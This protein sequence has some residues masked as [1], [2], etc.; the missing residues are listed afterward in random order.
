MKKLSLF[1]A[2]LALGLGMVGAGIAAY[3]SIEPEPVLAWSGTQ[4]STEGNY[5]ES[6]RGL[7]GDAL[8]EALDRVFLHPSLA[9]VLVVE[10]VDPVFVWG[11]AAVDEGR[12]AVVHRGG[13]DLEVSF[14][15]AQLVPEAERHRMILGGVLPAGVAGVVVDGDFL[16]PV[17]LKQLAVLGEFRNRSFVGVGW[18]D[19][20]D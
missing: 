2:S 12:R 5:Y 15:E 16:G 13:D 8:T 3:S 14:L 11:V 10:P 9:L 20:V 17:L 1:I 4:T 6:A 19:S 18:G 7:K